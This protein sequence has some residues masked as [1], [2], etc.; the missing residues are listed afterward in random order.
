MS[1]FKNKS[2]KISHN[3]KAKHD[4]HLEEVLYNSNNPTRRQ[5][6]LSRFNWICNA[7]NKYTD[8]K[9]TTILEIG[10]GSGTYL[11][12]LSTVADKVM[13]SDID[14]SYLNHAQNK[15]VNTNISFTID[16]ITKSRFDGNTFDFIL[17]SE[18]IE[19]IKES[20][21]AFFEIHRILKPGGILIMTTPQKYCP[22]ELLVKIISV[23]PGMKKL[24]EFVYKEPVPEEM[25]HINLMTNKTILK[26]THFV[27]LALIEK[28]K[29]GMY[30]PMIAELGGEPGM[31][32]LR[33]LEHHLRDSLWDWMLWTQCYV[34]LKS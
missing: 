23:L 24:A 7:I 32:L 22:L 1:I 31:K 19:H 13:V 27:N 14:K 6:H 29:C 16:D 12:K 20:Q 2:N 15:F 5:L 33:Y 21:R 34:F 11:S 4:L 17:C 9:N 26:Q 8:N 30:L 25:G 18:V 10:V 3:K 28:Y